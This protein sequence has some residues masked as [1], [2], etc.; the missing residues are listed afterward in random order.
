MMRTADGERVVVA[1]VTVE[2]A[3]NV[4]FVADVDCYHESVSSSRSHH[5][6]MKKRIG[7]KSIHSRSSIC[8]RYQRRQHSTIQRGD[9][10]KRAGSRARPSLHRPCRH[11]DSSSGRDERRTDDFS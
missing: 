2:L 9:Q 8:C 7:R 11:S 1:E 6:V 3:E 10:R 5:I 4:T